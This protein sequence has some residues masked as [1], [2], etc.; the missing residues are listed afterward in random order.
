MNRVTSVLSTLVSHINHNSISDCY[1]LGKFS[2]NK[3]PRPILIKLVNRGDVRNVLAMSGSVESPLR[4]KPDLD[5]VQRRTESFLL[6]ERWALIQSGDIK[7]RNNCLLV[8][9]EIVGSVVDGSYTTA[10]VNAES[11]PAEMSHPAEMSSNEPAISSIASTLASQCGAAPQAKD[12]LAHEVTSPPLSS[13]TQNS[14]TTPKSPT[15]I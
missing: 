2:P 6:K 4:L 10:K 15:S 3:R 9:R 8:K 13:Q 5:P 1:R 14:P 12:N 7:I 11:P